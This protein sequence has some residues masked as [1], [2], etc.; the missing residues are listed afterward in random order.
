M[1]SRQLFAG[2]GGFD[3]RYA[4]AYCED[5]DLAF[6][7]RERG[8]QVLYQP[9]SR[10][11]HFGGVSYGKHFTGGVTSFHALNRKR[12]RTRWHKLLSMEHL[13]HGKHVMQA[14][15]RAHHK[16]VILV[17]DR[18]VPAPDRDARSCTIICCIRALQAV[19][20]I[21]KFWPHDQRNSAGYTDALQDMG[22][23]VVYGADGSSFRQWMAENGEDVDHVL[24]SG[25]EIA[26]AFLR[27]V[28]RSC[29]GQLIYYGQYLHFRQLR[30]RAEALGGTALARA[31]DRMERW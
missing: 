19:G 20:M 22:V 3:D 13:P 25:P 8:Y 11:V 27:E 28:R 7:L 5:S 17:I 26:A 24:L 1:V 14:R 21:V 2:L 15:D 10:V 29:G 6:R 23:E 12:F 16:S 30:L 18:C 4:P 31:A 9:R